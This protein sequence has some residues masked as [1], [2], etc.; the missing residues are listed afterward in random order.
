[1][2]NFCNNVYKYLLFCNIILA[3][4]HDQKHIAAVLLCAGE[5][6]SRK[7]AAKEAAT[8]TGP[9]I[10][11]NLCNNGAEG[12]DFLMGI[13]KAL[14]NSGS[15]SDQVG[16][17]IDAL[18][19]LGPE[20]LTGKQAQLYTQLQHDAFDTW[21]TNKTTRKETQ[22]PFDR[23]AQQAH[24]VVIQG[25][26]NLLVSMTECSETQYATFVQVIQNIS[27]AHPNFVTPLLPPNIDNPSG[28]ET[29]YDIGS[30]AYG[31]DKETGFEHPVLQA[32]VESEREKDHRKG[33]VN[34]SFEEKVRHFMQS[35]NLVY[36]VHARLGG[37]KLPDT[38]MAVLQRSGALSLSSPYG[39]QCSTL[40]FTWDQVLRHAEYCRLTEILEEAD[41]T[42][43]QKAPTETEAARAKGKSKK[44]KSESVTDRY[45]RQKRVNDKKKD[46]A[47]V[48]D[49]AAAS[50]SLDAATESG[51]SKSVTG[52]TKNIAASQAGQIGAN[53]ASGTIDANAGAA[54]DI[55]VV[56]QAD[57][58][59]T[60]DSGD[61][62]TVRKNAGADG[63]TQ[64]PEPAHT[65]DANVDDYAGSGTADANAG[66]AIDI[67]VAH[68]AQPNNAADASNSGDAGTKAD[69]VPNND[70]NA[71]M[72]EPKDEEGDVVKAGGSAEPDFF[73][74]TYG[75][76]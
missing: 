51:T 50:N 56:G 66:A 40:E 25:S 37:D 22:T 59:D 41:D 68:Q 67:P 54:C 29:D 6:R 4:N 46:T 75:P 69:D 45:E 23:D 39:A 1:M 30:G 20:L 58:A 14:Q 63:D 52:T 70:E 10:L 21:T 11:A 55:P 3:Q 35:G 49:K 64:A 47:S 18:T 76:D 2:S 44:A 12:R 65:K 26:A 53:A 72:P 7:L 57:G 38:L 33:Y 31:D 62:G 16:H 42:E 8:L 5:G 34:G 61:T 15:Q 24:F 36:T 73:D 43:N 60:S 9:W 48:K 27:L 13:A 17:L 28:A 71:A 32:L 19:L 74:L